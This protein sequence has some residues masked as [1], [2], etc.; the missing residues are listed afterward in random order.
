VFWL[1]PV[2]HSATTAGRSR[3][4][5]VMLSAFLV[6]VLAVSG[7][8][9]Y[10]L[11]GRPSGDLN[12]RQPEP[13]GTSAAIRTPSPGVPA[14]IGDPTTVSQN[15]AGMS[16]EASSGAPSSV[17]PP[18]D[19]TASQLAGGRTSA[20]EAGTADAES[21]TPAQPP[22]ASRSSTDVPITEESRPT[23]PQAAV[24]GVV[25][26]HTGSNPSMA[27]N[28]D[29]T[30]G[31]PRRPRATDARVGVPSDA[32]HPQVCTEAVATLGLCS[33]N[34]SADTSMNAPTESRPQA[35]QTRVQRV[36]PKQA[37][38]NPSMTADPDPATGVPRASRA[39][40]ARVGVPTDAPRPRACTEAVAALGLCN[41]KTN[42][43]SK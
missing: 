18:T 5:R 30:A 14:W 31:V 38:S 13:E 37:V 11:P 35:T 12:T 42:G 4:P 32:P 25:P 27:T 1:V 22:A 21:Q 9:I 17:A 23:A 16:T 39:T 40:D 8:Y 28:T 20:T 19:E 3:I 10:R 36:V 29:L 26:K 15:T 2:R 43:E 24:Q 41:L 6:V 34:S 7:Y 33:L